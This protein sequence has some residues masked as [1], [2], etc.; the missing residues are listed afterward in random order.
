MGKPVSKTRRRSKF[1]D[2]PKVA[3][4]LKA[5]KEQLKREFV[6]CTD[7]DLTDMLEGRMHVVPGY[8]SSE[9]A[10]REEY[11]KLSRD[12]VEGHRALIRAEIERRALDGK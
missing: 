2:D 12:E 4:L 1:D 8:Y 7:G 6:L 5:T 11:A 3:A 10:A 9:E